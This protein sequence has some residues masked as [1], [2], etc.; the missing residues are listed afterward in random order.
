MRRAGHERGEKD[1][2]GVIL[3]GDHLFVRLHNDDQALEDILE[4]IKKINK[5]QWEE[6]VKR[7]IEKKEPDWKLLENLVT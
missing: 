5:R 4:K 2:Q 6:V 1:N 3:L 7:N